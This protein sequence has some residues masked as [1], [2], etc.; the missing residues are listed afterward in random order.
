MIRVFFHDGAHADLPEGTPAMPPARGF[1]PASLGEARALGHRAQAQRDDQWRGVR[2]ETSSQEA[3]RLRAE[4]DEARRL[5]ARREQTIARHERAWIAI[6]EALRGRGEALQT[7]EKA[8]ADLRA[9][10][11][12]ALPVVEVVRAIWKARD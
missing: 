3:Q 12:E 1:T 5:L 4:L 9:H 11:S 7:A 8:E 10:E 2:I 6:L